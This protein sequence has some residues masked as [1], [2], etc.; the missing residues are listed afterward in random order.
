M[1]KMLVRDMDFAPGANHMSDGRRLEVVVDG[2]SLFHGAQMAIDTTLLSVV[3]ADGTPRPRAAK[4]GGAALDDVGARKE[5]T[6]PELVGEGS[7]AKLVVLTAEV[8]GRWSTEAAQF[9]LALATLKVVSAPHASVR[10]TCMVPQVAKV[11]SVFRS[12]SFRFF[13]GTS[14]SCLRC[15]SGPVGARRDS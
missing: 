3:R 6:H 14:F 8:G 5:V 7:R 1:T 13:V 15:R 11:V 9:I 2:L 10:G 4:K 12:A